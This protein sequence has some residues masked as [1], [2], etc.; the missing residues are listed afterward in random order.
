[1]ALFPTAIKKRAYPGDTD[2]YWYTP[3][4][5]PTGSGI[6]VDERTA[7]KYLTLFSCVSLIA[8]DIGRLPLILYRRFADGSK[9][10]VVDHPLYD[11]LHN[12][13]N[14]DTTSFNWRESSESH[15]LLWGNHYSFIERNKMGQIIALW[16]LPDPGAVK[17]ER[18]GGKIVYT[19]KDENGKKVV[20]TRDQ[21]FH[22]PGFGFSGLVGMSMVALAREAIGLGLATETFGTKYFSNGTHPS[23]IITM[24]KDLGEDE[25]A[26]KKAL[27]EQYAGLGNSHGLM[28]FQNGEEYKSLTVPPEDAQFLETRNFQKTEICGMYHV[29]PHKVAKHGQNS[30]YN[31]LEQEN[32]SYVDSCLTHWATRWEQQISLQLLTAA[33]RKAGLFAEFNMNGLLRGDTAARGEFY[34]K[35]F[36]VGGISP[37]EIAAKENM[38]PDPNPAADERYV[39]L[40][41][42]PLSQ[43]DQQP[44]ITSTEPSDDEDRSIRPA[45]EARSIAI[46]DRISA[47][48]APLI[49]DSAQTVVNRETKAVKK[50]ANGPIEGFDIF[51]DDFYERFP[52]YINQK[53]GPVL[54]SY[55]Q[56]VVDASQFEIDDQSGDFNDQIDEYIQSYAARHVSSSRGQLDALVDEGNTEGIAE[57]ADQW[58]ERR[59]EKIATDETV[60]VAGA[61]FSWVVFGAGLSM[62][63]RNRG[64]TC[65]YCKSLNGKR[66]TQAKPLLTEGDELDPKAGDGPMKFF[67]TKFHTPIHQGCDCYMSVGK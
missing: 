64:K 8:G 43:A 2:D 42:V 15:L 23:G 57:R 27:R 41:M 20:R 6:P 33:E 46:R 65:P 39:M 59:P 53:M 22:I 63:L 11:I 60:R 67:E 45:V 28:L 18:I 51:L 40:N 34:S 58:Q 61:A 54:R 7:L 13:P 25:D 24:D 17:V 21:V 19:Y 52:A 38:N 48:Y 29:P 12:A 49:L 55:L 5:F 3:R 66:S 47:R 9:E 35:L 37:N 32:T 56:A 31:N 62:I 10:R 36:S 26:Y 1:M 4:A 16:Q 30:N 14:P 44:V 50:R